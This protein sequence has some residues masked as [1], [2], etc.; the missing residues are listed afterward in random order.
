MGSALS[1]Y[2]CEAV[3]TASEARKLSRLDEDGVTERGMIADGEGG[4]CENMCCH[5]LSAFVLGGSRCGTQVD[6]QGE[7]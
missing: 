6:W 3:S 1:F 5:A 4:C 2:A 7:G